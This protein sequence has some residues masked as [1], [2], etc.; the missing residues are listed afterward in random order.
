MVKEPDLPRD[1]SHEPLAT[2][3]VASTVDQDNRVPE[4]SETI[5][6]VAVK[7]SLGAAATESER[8]IAVVPPAPVQ[9]NV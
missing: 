9:V 7:V 2:Q 3:S 5:V 6:D 4:P 8:V 1:P